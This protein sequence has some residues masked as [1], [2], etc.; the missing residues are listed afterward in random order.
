MTISKLFQNLLACRRHKG[1]QKLCPAGNALNEVPENCF[2]TV[3]FASSFAS[4]HGIVSSIY[5]L[6]RLKRLKNFLSLHLPH[7]A[8][9]SCLRLLFGVFSVTAFRSAS[10]SSATPLSVTVPPKYLFVMETVLLT[11]FPSVLARSDSC[12]LPSVPM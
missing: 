1:F 10:T 2:Q 6:Q 12:A 11:R 9:P 7:A 8:L 4:T 5:L 3:F